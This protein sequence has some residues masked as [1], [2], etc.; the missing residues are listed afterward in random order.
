MSKFRGIIHGGCLLQSK[1]STGTSL[2]FN[3]ETRAQQAIYFGEMAH[4][5][6]LSIHKFRRKLHPE[7]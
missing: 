5:K 6:G 7:H 2:L 4:N 1:P 3:E